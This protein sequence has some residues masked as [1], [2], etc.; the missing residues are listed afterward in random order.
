MTNYP[1]MMNHLNKPKNPDAGERP[2]HSYIHGK[3]FS[4]NDVLTSHKHLHTG[5][6]P[7]HCNI[8]G[9]SFSDSS[10]L[11]I[12]KCIHTGEKPY[13][14]DICGKS[15]SQLG[16]LTYRKISYPVDIKEISYIRCVLDVV[17]NI[18]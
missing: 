11:V 9:K 14:C 17:I 4:E 18:H 15:F 3:S 2:Y 1:L 13:Q 6:K 12:H 7:Y 5:E 8:C 16:N 10:Q